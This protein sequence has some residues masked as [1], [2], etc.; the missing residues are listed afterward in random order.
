MLYADYIKQCNSIEDIIK[1]CESSVPIKFRPVPWKHPDLLHGIKL[2]ES[3]DAL[4]CYMSAY[5]DMHVTKC[6]AAMMNFPYDDI[7]ECIE[8]VDWGCG[9]GIGSATVIQC[10]SQRDML[11]WVRKVTLIE[12]SYQ[13]MQRA[14]DNIKRLTLGAV[15]IETKNLFLPSQAIDIDKEKT[16]QTIGYR[17]NIVIHVFS[18]ILDVQSI[19]IGMVAKLVAHSHGKHYVLCIGP[20][21]RAS[22]RIEE[23]CSVFGEQKYFSRIDSERYA[24]TLNSGHYYTCMTRC[25]EYNGASIDLNRMSSV[26]KNNDP[27]FDEYNFELQIQN[28][29]L[30]LQ[31]ARIAWRLR[32]I[33]C[34]DDVMYI[35]ADI[36]DVTVD[37]LIVRPNKGIIL[38]NVFDDN[39]N[40]CQISSIENKNDEYENNCEYGS[41]YAHKLNKNSL[42]KVFDVVSYDKVLK[43]P[44]NYI[45]SCHNK[46]NSA[47][48]ELLIKTVEDNRSF[49]LI[50]KV[51][52][53]P[54]NSYE[55]I[56][57]FLY[58]H[59]AI[60][61]HI[62]TY[63]KEFIEIKEVSHT[64]YRDVGL[65]DNI[66]YFDEIIRR[67]LC[68]I[69]SPSWHS[70]QEGRIDIKPEGPQKNLSESKKILQKIC[71]VAG[72][73]KTQVLAFRVVNALK[74]TGGNILVLTF[75]ITLVNYLKLR[76][77]EIREDFPWGK[78][79]IYNYHHF[80]KIQAQRYSLNTRINSYDNERFFDQSKI[81][82]KYS[83]IFIDEVQDYKP[84]WLH[85]IQKNFLSEHDGEMVVFGGAKQNVY[86]R[87]LDSNGD[88]RLGVFPGTWNRK[89]CT[90]RRLL[91][92]F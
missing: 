53:F 76:L 19:D 28:G 44:F 32:N 58:N 91:Q 86:E 13:A 47:I 89:L 20:K 78:I 3:D 41:E 92:L 33:L 6:R 16:V 15:E 63:G 30:S 68:Q 46:I 81:K 52:I 12:P 75:N 23:F 1:F 61:K 60:R 80:F 27:V 45:K 50:K 66:T 36:N 8:I 77:S 55:E 14:L 57:R 24:R 40:K 31:K 74:R 56:E 73:G 72:S 5:G 84:E 65:L 69:I 26:C 18:N 48:E 49:S 59:D 29:V 88:I 79:E 11:K 87:P 64:L 67:K 38:I 85:I 39:L 90:S 62:Y 42:I 43:A 7:N 25:F 54:E 70:F 21:N 82:Q 35:D 2:L 22:Y 17:Y 4:N 83:A 34:Q 51:I 10:L 71:G 9:Q 37:F